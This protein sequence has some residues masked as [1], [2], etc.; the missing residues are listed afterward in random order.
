MDVSI[1]VFD[2]SGRLLWT[3]SERGVSS[4][5][6]YTIDWDLCQDGGSRLPTGVYLYRVRVASDGSAEA[7]KARKLVV[8]SNK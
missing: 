4:P 6:A 8:I 1:D 2:M 7:S 5:G 3:H